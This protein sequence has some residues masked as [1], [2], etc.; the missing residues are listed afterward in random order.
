MYKN[1]L[2]AYDE[3]P[4]SDQ[5]IQVAINH[6]G[7]QQEAKV[8][9]VNITRFTGP[10]TN[11]Q[12]ARSIHND[13]K[14]DRQAELWH[15]KDR[16]I[17]NEIDNLIEVLIAEDNENPGKIICR[18]ADE[19]KIDLIVMGSRGLGNVRKIL[20]GSVSNY[21]VQRAQCPILIIK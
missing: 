21:V 5:A 16:F 2:V 1:I 6:A 13:L 19:N 20:L 18:Y 15:L 12:L 7:R 3:S 17:D 10:R 9:I 4:L 11:V 8:H 14:K